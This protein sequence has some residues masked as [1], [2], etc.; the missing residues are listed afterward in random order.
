MTSYVGQSPLFGDFPYQTLPGDGGTSYT[1]SYKVSNE[2]GLLVFVDGAI[3]RPGDDYTAGGNTL[4]F[5]SAVAIG[6]Q[7]FTYG[8]GFPKSTLSTSA[9]SINTTELAAGV[10]ANTVEAQ[11]WTNA[12]KLL[13][14]KG[15]NDAFKGGN[16]AFAT[17]A[18]YQKIPGGMIIQ[19][20]GLAL[21]VDD[22]IV[23]FP[24]TFP[25][26]C[27]AVVVSSAGFNEHAAG[28][29]AWNTANFAA[30]GKTAATAAGVGFPAVH[31]IAIGY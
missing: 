23:T 24:V 4:T 3:K 26:A 13:S 7:I 12:V 30:Q 19:W 9:G 28:A 18:S 6:A 15:L 14:P 21:T 5:T 31:W 1:L 8:M 17:A 25:T 22:Q 27:T 16:Q 29:A 2:N 20:G 11:D 10:Y